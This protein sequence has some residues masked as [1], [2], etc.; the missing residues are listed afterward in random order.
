MSVTSSS[1]AAQREYWISVA[2]RLAGP[3]LTNLA[4]RTLKA[5]MPVERKESGVNAEY[6]THL[7]A[8]GR[9]LMGLAPWFELGEE[10]SEPWRR[11]ALEAMDAA[12]DPASPDRC[13]FR[14]PRQALVD[15][16]FLCQALL[17][18]PTALREALEPGVKRNLVLALKE[19]RGIKPSFNNWL[20]FS[21][22]VEMGLYLLGEG[23]WDKTRIDYAL[24]M[25]AIWYKGDG[26]YGDGPEYHADYY[27]AFVIQPML[28]DI[29]RYLPEEVRLDLK[30][31]PERIWERA[32]KY[33][34]LQE[35][36]ISPEGTFPPMGRS[37]AYR[38]GALQVLAQ[39]AWLE[40]LPEKMRPAQARCAMT[41]VIRRMIEAPGTFDD[42]G[43]LRIGFCGAQP[44]IGE[45]YISTGSLYLCAAGLLP[46]GLP[47]TAAFWSEPDERWTALKAWSGEP[48]PIDKRIHT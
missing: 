2:V 14:E 29:M 4:N 38:F 45:N 27:N 10:E 48:F 30:E 9:L 7:E 32:V 43:W 16:A 39:M 37:L 17:R 26:V 40:K 13:H 36:M 21:A 41:E 22:M 31:F 6:S 3:V 20:L 12:T 46:L 44:G 11:L 35:R 28:V 1:G 5:R 23:D 24:R 15:A 18:A 34:D 25:H 47:G 42:E 8:L 19:T 33:A